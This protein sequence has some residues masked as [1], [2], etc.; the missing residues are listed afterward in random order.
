MARI[1]DNIYVTPY[2]VNIY[3]LVCAALF[4]LD[5]SLW[6]NLPALRIER[7]IPG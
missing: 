1:V 7:S 3:E 6:T 2:N 5:Y 4:L